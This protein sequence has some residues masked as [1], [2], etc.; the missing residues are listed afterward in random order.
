MSL[1]LFL[2]LAKDKGW[3]MNKLR[4]DGGTQYQR[5]NGQ[6]FVIDQETFHVRIYFPASPSTP[7]YVLFQF[8]WQSGEFC[9]KLQ[10]SQ[11]IN[12]KLPLAWFDFLKSR[13]KDFGA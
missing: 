7:A 3:Q 10:Y 8:S 11:R 5:N 12:H 1:K 2:N 9:S 4:G 6:I 13:L